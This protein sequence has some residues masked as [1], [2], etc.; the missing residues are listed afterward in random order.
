MSPRLHLMAIG[1]H[2]GDVEIAAGAAILK[3][4]RAGH[5]ATIVHLTLGA[6]GH[7]TL[8]EAD[9]SRQKM[10]EAAGVAQA[11]GADVRFFPYLDAEL[12]ATQ[13]AK[14]AVAD[15]IREV[16][17]TH[18]FGHWPGSIHRDHQAASQIVQEAM[19]Y[20]PLPTVPTAHPACDVLGPYLME[21]WED[22]HGY[23]PRIYLDVG[24]VFAD[25]VRAVQG[26]EL[27]KGG[28]SDFDYIGYYSALATLRGT[29][30]GFAKAVTFST[31][32]PLTAFLG[33]G[34][35]QPV[36]LYTTTS[37]IFRPHQRQGTVG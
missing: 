17:P 5:A 30:A 8:S 35:D 23:E 20:A 6:K 26:Y 16:R 27:F 19:F 2:A 15:L 28:V 9:Y 10:A 32:A 36:T 14:M 1:A 29:T 22:P 7:P 11:L 13:E 18:V 21:N 25:W 3:H 33:S 31:P 37:P 24:D 4:T 34:F 12:E